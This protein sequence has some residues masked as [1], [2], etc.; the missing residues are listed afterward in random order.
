MDNIEETKKTEK[1]KTE[2]AEIKKNVSNP[3][4]DKFDAMVFLNSLQ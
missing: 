4:N 1:M 2:L 3:N